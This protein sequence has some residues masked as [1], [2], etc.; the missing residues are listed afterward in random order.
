V[1]LSDSVFKAD[2][3]DLY[4]MMW[5]KPMSESEFAARMAKLIND[6]IKTAEV[7]AGIPVAGGS[8]TGGA[9]SGATTGTGKL[10]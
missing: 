7:L 6:Q 8:A 9:V 3:L 1:A 4:T 2:L 5:K 10:S